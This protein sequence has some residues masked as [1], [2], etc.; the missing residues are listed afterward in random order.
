MKRFSFHIL[1]LLACT[2]L[3]A[4]QTI[5]VTITNVTNGW[6]NNSVNTVIFRKNSLT[7]FKGYQYIAFYDSAQNV[8]LGKRKTGSSDWQ[9]Q[10]TQYKGNVSDAHN[11]ISIITDGNGYLHLA[12]DHHN[13]ALRYARSVSPGSLQMN[14]KM[15]MTGL[16]E[17]KVSYPEFYRLSGG[18]LIFLYRNGASGNGSLVMNRYD[19]KTSTWVQ[20]QQNLID[21]ENKRSAYWQAS[22]DTKGSI[23]LSWVWRETGDVASNHDLCYARSDDGGLTWE[24]SDGTKYELPINAANAEYIS[25]IPQN[26]DLINQTSI[27]TDDKGQPMIA[28]YY[29]EVNDSVPQYHLFRF[30]GNKWQLLNAGFNNS[31][32]HLGGTGTKRIPISRPQVISWKQNKKTAVAIIFRDAGRGDAVSIAINHDIELNTWKVQDIMTGPVGSWEPSFDTNL[33]NDKK[34]LSLFIQKTEQLDGEGKANIP[35][36]MVKVLDCT[37]A[38]LTR[39]KA[40][41]E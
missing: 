6:A 24:R 10:V 30:S 35:A 40:E 3:A 39:K 31:V 4:Q 32:F 26:S 36:Q 12:W 17:T 15:P 22:V 28:T 13:V 18:D 11:S 34:I 33:W 7:S 29:K 38:A 8:V 2:D 9:L 16:N 20:V 37:K 21:G 23:H 41:G 1:C 14:A 27:T 5:P 19:L 25:R